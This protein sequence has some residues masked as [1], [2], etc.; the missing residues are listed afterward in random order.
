MCL[1]GEGG[2]TEAVPG[3]KEW[4]TEMCG[5]KRE[6]FKGHRKGPEG[7]E[8]HKRKTNGPFQGH[9][10]W[11]MASETKRYLREG[12]TRR[13]LPPQMTDTLTSIHKIAGPLFIVA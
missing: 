9:N 10:G 7:R 12:Q 5:H 1:W 6:L 8:K 2:G 11:L 3:Q 4:S 13:S